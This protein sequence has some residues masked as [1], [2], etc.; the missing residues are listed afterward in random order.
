MQK[1]KNIVGV[2]KLK[3]KFISLNSWN[4][5]FS[6]YNQSQELINYHS[7]IIDNC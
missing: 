5:Y 2:R 7:M 1:P 6:S 3:L 4:L